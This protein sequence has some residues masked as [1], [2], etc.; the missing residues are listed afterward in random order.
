[1]SNYKKQF[2][3][4]CMSVTDE[5]QTVCPVCK[6][7]TLIPAEENVL[8]KIEDF[9]RRIQLEEEESEQTPPHP[10]KRMCTKCFHILEDEEEE[11]AE[12]RNTKWFHIDEGLSEAIS[13]FNKS[14][15]P[16]AMSCQ[17]G[18]TIETVDYITGEPLE[19]PETNYGFPY[20][21]FMNLTMSQ[22]L[23]IHLYIINNLYPL[24]KVTIERAHITNM[25]TDP[26]EIIYGME[27]NWHREDNIRVCPNRYT[28]TFIVSINF[29]NRFD[30]FIRNNFD[31]C[32]K[33]WCEQVTRIAR[34]VY[35]V[36]ESNI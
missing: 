23:M 2:C 27:L 16:T 8:Q 5:T 13:L 4:D 11:C 17:G 10:T 36:Q 29:T 32:C 18:R 7:D 25:A 24:L 20:V 30:S 3:P 28:D 33:V 34:Q 1:M 6:C 19:K 15:Y 21:V 35:D 26:E 22:A 31:E 9:M 12:C 14:G